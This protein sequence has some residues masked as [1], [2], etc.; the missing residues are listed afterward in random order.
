ML[1]ASLQVPVRG[2]IEPTDH[3]AGSVVSDF[4]ERFPVGMYGIDIDVVGGF[5]KAHT[6]F[7]SD[8][9]CELKYLLGFPSMPSSLAESAGLLAWYGLET[10]NG[11]PGRLQAP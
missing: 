2:L 11:S 6:A 7:P 10:V 4:K 1:Q 3:S 5:K 8:D 9:L